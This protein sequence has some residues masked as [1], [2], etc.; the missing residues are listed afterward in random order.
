[1]SPQIVKPPHYER[2][3]SSIQGENKSRFVGGGEREREHV[4]TRLT[5]LLV[6]FKCPLHRLFVVI[7]ISPPL[8]CGYRNHEIF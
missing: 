1:M 8:V 4:K 5:I 6:W 7:E 2:L 3:F